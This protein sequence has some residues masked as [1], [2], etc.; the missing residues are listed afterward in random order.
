VK[1]SSTK[2]IIG[3]LGAIGAGKSTVAAEFAKLGCGVIQADQ[4]N[5]QLLQQPEIIAQLIDWW[6]VRVI[7]PDG[8]VNRQ[9][10]GDIVFEDSREL[11]KLTLLLH[12]LIEA[13][14]QELIK[15]YQ[16][17]PDINAIILD[18]PLLAEVGYSKLCDALV[19]VDTSKSARFDR[20]RKKCGWTAEKI[21]K[22]ENLQLPLD[23]KAKMS[24]YT[25]DNNSDIPVT[26]SQ[27]GRV[28]TMVLQKHP[29]K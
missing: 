25:I 14:Q 19:Y 21:K 16:S 12:P 9:A 11:K 15:S 22:V 5:H 20:L 1:S 3:I 26:T 28:L 7:N 10:L 24:E 27:V 18:V 23:K 4:L 17:D 8:S 2:P 29:R 6:G 13:R